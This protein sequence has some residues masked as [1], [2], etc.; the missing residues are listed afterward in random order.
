[1][2]I[3]FEGGFTFKAIWNVT[4]DVAPV[5]NNYFLFHS[6]F[7]NQKHLSERM[8][9]SM[10]TDKI[11]PILWEPHFVALDRRVGIIL[12]GIRDCVHKNAAEDVVI[13]NEAGDFS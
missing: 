13:S 9:E 2:E 10:S 6:R 3:V 12:N 1:M 7:H 5:I 11:A 8:R 4:K